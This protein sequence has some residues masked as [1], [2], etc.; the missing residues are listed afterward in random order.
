MSI[1][2]P[3]DGVDTS[4]AP[5]VIVSSDTHAGLQCEEY[6]PYLDSALHDEF[7]VYVAGRHEHRRVQ[8]EV[9]AEFLAEWEGENADGLR[10]AYDPE[11]RDKELDA[12]GIAGEVIFADGDAVTGQ[13]S[14]PFGAGL[15][16]GQITDPRQ[17]FGGA[18]A[19]NRWLVDFCAT[20]RPSQLNV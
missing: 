9:N 12:D 14:P 11:V 1:A 5:Y 7:D 8:E 4:N 17:A 2:N 15:S 6:R 3:T 18:Q 13:E 16:A 10:G 20:N 19:H